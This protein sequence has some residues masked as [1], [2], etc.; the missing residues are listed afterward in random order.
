MKSNSNEYSKNDKKKRVPG[1]TD[2]ILYSNKIEN[3]IKL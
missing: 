2:R 3:N 1:W